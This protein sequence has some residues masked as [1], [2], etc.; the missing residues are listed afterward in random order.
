MNY[1]STK[2]EEELSAP[3]L[4]PSEVDD[5]DDEEYMELLADDEESGDTWRCGCTV[6]RI[7]PT[8][9]AAESTAEFS[10]RSILLGLIQPLFLYIQFQLA[11]KTDSILSSAT[12][13]VFTT[14]TSFIYSFT[15]VQILI[16]LF[17]V[18]GV[19][20]RTTLTTAGNSASNVCLQLLPEITTDIILLLVLL[21]YTDVA[22]HM[23]TTFTIMF[24]F[25]AI[26]NS[27]TCHVQYY[28]EEPSTPDVNE[29]DIT[30]HTRSSSNSTKDDDEL[31]T[32]AV[33]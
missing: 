2:N 24:C 23:V 18:S 31:L 7:V 13:D 26:G 4:P 19:L 8:A 17:T 30:Y 29:L 27:C 1:T 28:T 12:S 9:P 16:V 14:S 22:V 21:S 20:Y 10:V 32:A 15:S 25:I 5:D 6:E 3:L 11:Y 33:V